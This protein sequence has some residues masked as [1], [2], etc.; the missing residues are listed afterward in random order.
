M[1]RRKNRILAFQ[2]IYSWDVNSAS[3]EELLEFNWVDEEKLER[4]GGEN[5]LFARML[6]SGT[7]ENIEKIDDT[8]KEHLTNWDFDRINRVDLAILR[9][10]TYAIMFQ[11][12]MPASI[13]IDEAIDISKEYG[14]DDSFK[15]INAIL[16]SIRKSCRAA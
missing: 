16:D 4:M 2:A 6:I 13:V 10:S 8:I 5:L 1:A 3:L 12:D 14:S 7:I 11:S 9:M 15:F